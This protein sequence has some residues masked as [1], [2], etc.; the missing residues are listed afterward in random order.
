VADANEIEACK[1]RLRAVLPHLKIA[2]NMAKLQVPGGTVGLGIIVKT[3]DGAGRVTA[4][5]EGEEF[6]R[7]LET[8]VGDPF[9]ER[10]AARTAGLAARQSKEP[11]DG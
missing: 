10:V 1:E 3:S 6:L 11:S 2:M 8:L 5:F 9:A 7:D 4:S